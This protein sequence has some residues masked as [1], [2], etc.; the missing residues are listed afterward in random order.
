MSSSYPDRSQNRASRGSGAERTWEAPSLESPQRSFR[1]GRLNSHGTCR[2]VSGIPPPHTDCQSRRL[3][4]PAISS[5]VS[6]GICGTA[7]RISETPASSKALSTHETPGGLSCS[8]RPR[9]NAAISSETCTGKD[10]TSQV[11]EARQRPT[12]YVRSSRTHTGL[13]RKQQVG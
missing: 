12:K 8:G 7:E 9:A 3:H 5:T 11:R 6:R 10:E 1:R 4:G 2:Q 13:L